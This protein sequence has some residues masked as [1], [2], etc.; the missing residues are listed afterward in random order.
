[1]CSSDL[2]HSGR[3]AIVD[4]RA[5]LSDEPGMSPMELWCN[6]SQERYVLVIAADRIAAFETLCARERCPH[7]VI[8]TLTDDGRL[9]V[10]D[11]LHGEEPVDMPIEVLLGKT[12][13]MLRDVKTETPKTS[14]FDLTA[15]EPRE[16]L[17][18]VLRFPAVADKTFLITI[19][20]RTVGGM[21]SRDQKIGRAHV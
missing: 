18:R 14:A 7:A 10:R 5:V 4:L 13:R 16:A 20:D 12:P 8:G 21:I 17:R 1:M 2:A 3:G 15:L 9:L 11:P 6:E 19:G